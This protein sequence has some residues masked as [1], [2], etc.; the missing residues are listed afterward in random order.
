MKPNRDSRNAAHRRG[1]RRRMPIVAILAMAATCAA[2]VLLAAPGDLDTTFGGGVVVFSVGSVSD[3]ANGVSVLPDGRVL[4]D[5][6][7]SSS[8]VSQDLLGADATHGRRRGGSFVRWRIGQGVFQGWRQ[9]RNIRKTRWCALRTDREG[10]WN[11][12]RLRLCAG[13]HGQLL[14]SLCGPKECRRHT[15]Q[16]FRLRWFGI[17]IVWQVQLCNRPRNGSR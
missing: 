11:D 10:Q 7:G 3:F 16:R 13:Q 2:P 14:Q 4:A 9:F 12:H 15:R 5:Q 17:R 6:Q 1:L 8:T